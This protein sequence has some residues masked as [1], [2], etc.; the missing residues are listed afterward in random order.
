MDWSLLGIIA[1]LLSCLL[2]SRNCLLSRVEW[3]CA[4]LIDR[5]PAV[6]NR[7][8]KCFVPDFGLINYKGELWK[9][10]R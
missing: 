6:R 5:E 7:L 8:G 4:L 2:L 1:F 3:H 9:E 10:K